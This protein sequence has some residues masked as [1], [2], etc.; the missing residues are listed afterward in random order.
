MYE[1]PKG[2]KVSV[3]LKDL[4]VKIFNINYDDRL[5]LHEIINHSFFLEE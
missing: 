4:I 1:I 2:V 5:T 3:E